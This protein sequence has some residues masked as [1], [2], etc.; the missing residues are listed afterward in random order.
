MEVARAAKVRIHKKVVKWTTVLLRDCFMMGSQKGKILDRLFEESQGLSF[1]EA[2]RIA[3][4]REA[5]LSS[6]EADGRSIQNQRRANLPGAVC[7]LRHHPRV[8]HPEEQAS[9]KSDIRHHHRHHQGLIPRCGV[10]FVDRK[11]IQV[12]IS[13]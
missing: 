10:P 3:S 5:A 11:V 9:W 8:L 7:A 12:H 6:S 13:F 2:V 4:S 1:E